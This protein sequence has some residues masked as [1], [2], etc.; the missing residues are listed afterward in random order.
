MKICKKNWGVY[1][2]GSLWVCQQIFFKYLD[3]VMERGDKS[4]KNGI[5]VISTGQKLTEILQ[6]RIFL[7]LS[8]L[9]QKCAVGTG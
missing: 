4:L 9:C 2:L 1:G 3:R 5:F 6:V 8:H 7:F